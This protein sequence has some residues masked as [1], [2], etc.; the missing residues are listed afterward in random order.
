[1]LVWQTTR[2]P[3]P[4]FFIPAPSFVMESLVQFLDQLKCL[5]SL[6]NQAH[7]QTLKDTITGTYKSNCSLSVALF[8]VML[9]KDVLV[10]L[11]KMILIKH[12]KGAI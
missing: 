10:A 7:K 2:H 4:L 9:H 8:T 5:W 12:T 1:M 3:H 6:H 11:F